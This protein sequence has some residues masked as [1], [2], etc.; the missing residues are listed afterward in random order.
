MKTPLVSIIV[1]TYNRPNFLELTL[2]SIEAQTFQDFE[3]LVVDD[4]SQG[5]ENK[6][7]CERNKKIKYQ[8]IPNSGGPAL[9]RN[10]GI[11][12]SRGKYIAFVDDDDLWPP[13]KLEKQIQVLENHP[14]FGLVHGYCKVIDEFGKETGEIIGKPGSPSVKHGDV[15]MKM[16]GNWTLMMPTVLIRK[17]VI[18][19]VGFFNTHMP[20]AG[21]DTEFWTRCSFQTKFYYLDEPLA[22]YR[23]HQSNSRLLKKKY[24]ELPGYLKKV[25]DNAL[26][27]QHIDVAQHKILRNHII[28]KQIKEMNVDKR[29]TF[30]LLFKLNPFWFLNFGNCKLFILKLLK[31]L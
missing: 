3:V 27:Q 20:Q 5:I 24:L 13:S 16:A 12:E 29:K 8:K 19:A 25:I 14:D 6:I 30:S 4:G 11:K 28:R 17:N 15:K 1:P 10:F 2:Q 21:E 23:R 7:L 22:F 18:E 31:T 9:P 26:E